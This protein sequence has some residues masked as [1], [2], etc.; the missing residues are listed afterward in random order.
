MSSER[1][2][3]EVRADAAR[4]RAIADKHD[5][6]GDKISAEICRERATRLEAELAL[7]EPSHVE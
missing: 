4:L 7:M 6:H 5:Y 1:T 3:D 2:A